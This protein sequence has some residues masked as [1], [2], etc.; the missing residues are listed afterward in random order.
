MKTP[1]FFYSYTEKI[2]EERFG[3]FS[4]QYIVRSQEEQGR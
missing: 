4:P 2:A 3:V 1:Y